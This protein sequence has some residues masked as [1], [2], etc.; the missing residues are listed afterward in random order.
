MKIS[1]TEFQRRAAWC[2]RCVAEA[3]KVHTPEELEAA[4]SALLSASPEQVS[5]RQLDWLDTLNSDNH[6]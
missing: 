4:W 3:E 2:R 5:Q 1:D 6:H